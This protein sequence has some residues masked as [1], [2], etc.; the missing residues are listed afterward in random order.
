[1][2]RTYC[3]TIETHSN[4]IVLIACVPISDS[5]HKSSMLAYYLT[6]NSYK[7]CIIV[8]LYILVHEYA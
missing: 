5:V 2:F 1:M 7:V 8:V 3:I 6:V 4:L